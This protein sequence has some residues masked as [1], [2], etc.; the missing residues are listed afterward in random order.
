MKTLLLLLF[1]FY[2][3]ISV[4]AQVT[5]SIQ[6][7][8]NFDQDKILNIS[9]SLLQALNK[10]SIDSTV[11][12]EIFAFTDTIGSIDYN[13]RLAFR[14]L[15][16]VLQFI[17]TNYYATTTHIIGESNSYDLVKNRRVDVVIS[18]RSSNQFVAHDD[19]VILDIQFYNNSPIIL[20]KC[21]GELE[22]LLEYVIAHPTMKVELHGHVCCGPGYDLS[23]D[24]ALSVKQFLLEN[25]IESDRIQCF[26]HSNDQPRYKETSKYYEQLNRRV[27]CV[28][29]EKE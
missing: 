20:P 25:D 21:S 27:E 8:F 6:C 16:S 28:F 24:R 29:K 22:K 18:E 3:S 17:D 4:K 2:S 11:Q 1:A 9:D 26:G 13:Q 19:T 5:D 23:V 14:R 12:L 7:F 15:T 10:K